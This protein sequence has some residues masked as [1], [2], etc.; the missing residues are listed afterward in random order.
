L[1]KGNE[2]VSVILFHDVPYSVPRIE[3]LYH[4]QRFFEDPILLSSPDLVQS[5]VSSGAFTHFIEISG[6]TKLHFSPEASDDLML[7]FR[8]FGYN[9]L[10]PR[11]V[12]RRDFP[13]GEENVHELLQEL[14]RSPKGTTVEAEF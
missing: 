11:L 14:D 3:W 10:I 4:C 9:N 8:E 5:D 2:A 12:P 1:Q 6:G 7:L 13:R